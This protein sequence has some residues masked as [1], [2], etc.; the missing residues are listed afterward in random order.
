LTRPSPQAPRHQACPRI[1]GKGVH[2][3]AAEEGPNGKRV[4]GQARGARRQN[5]AA[6]RDDRRCP[7]RWRRGAFGGGSL[8]QMLGN[9]PADVGA[10]ADPAL[11]NSLRLTAARRPAR[12]CFGRD[13]VRLPGPGWRAGAS[14][15]VGAPAEWRAACRRRAGGRGAPRSAGPVA[16]W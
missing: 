1:E 2:R 7:G 8:K 3:G 11:D 4:M 14:R 10:G 15:P 16:G 13:S 5:L 9:R 6:S 12:Q